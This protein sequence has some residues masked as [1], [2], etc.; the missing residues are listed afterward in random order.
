MGKIGIKT[1]EELAEK[2]GLNQ[3]TIHRI[4]KDESHNPTYNNLVKVLKALQSPCLS[5]YPNELDIKIVSQL[6][7]L[8]DKHKSILL[9]T[10]HDFEELSKAI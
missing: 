6:K 9:R 3:P 2:A 8:D 4:I 7:D 1:E 10:L 5:D